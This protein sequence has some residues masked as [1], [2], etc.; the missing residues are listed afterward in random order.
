LFSKGKVK[1]VMEVYRRAVLDANQEWLEFLETLAGQTAIAIESISLFHNLELSNTEL[2]AAYDATIEGW[3]FALDLRDAD[4]EGHTLRVTQKTK[5]LAEAMGLRGDD[6]V[7][8]FRGALLHDIGKMGVPDNILHKPG[9]LTDQEWQVM[10]KHPEY[11][12][13]WL[14]PT[15][16][17]RPALDIPYCH[18]EKWDGTG[19]PRGLKEDQI[20]LK[21]RI[22]SVIDVWDALSSDRPYRSKW[23]QDKVVNYIREQSGSYFDPKIV[24]VFM[25]LLNDPNFVQ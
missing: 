9:P 20:P 10:R 4:T 2:L 17:L 5:Q 15:T 22:F 6:L 7:Q 21:A 12:Y 24:P 18:H 25:E 8:V 16:Y 14:H 3:S 11:A 13:K 23:P 19:Y 1:G